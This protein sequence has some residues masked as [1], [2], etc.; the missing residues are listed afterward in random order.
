M[1]FELSESEVKYILH[2]LGERRFAKIAVT[3]SASLRN[4]LDKNLSAEFEAKEKERAKADIERIVAEFTK[5]EILKK[6]SAND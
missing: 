5:L 1:Q 2:L 3:L 6:F 4:Q